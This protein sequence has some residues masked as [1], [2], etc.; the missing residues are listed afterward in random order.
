MRRSRRLPRVRALMP[1]PAELFCAAA[2]ALLLFFAFPDFSVWPLAW[3]ALVPLLFNIARRPRAVQ[4]FLS[5]WLAGTLFFSASC[6][7]LTYPMIHYAGIPA[8]LAYLLLLPPAAAGGG[9]A[10]PPGGAGAH[11]PTPR[12]PT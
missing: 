4:S 1:S 12:T 2:S 6:Y 9:F 10:A 3:V 5:G 7:W 11:A 8:P